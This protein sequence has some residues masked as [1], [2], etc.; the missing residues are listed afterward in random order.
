MAKGTTKKADEATESG[1][2]LIAAA[3]KMS[4]ATGSG[5]KEEE[6]QS[7]QESGEQ[8]AGQKREEQSDPQKEEQSG[9]TPEGAG[10]TNE[11]AATGSGPN[12]DENSGY[13]VY[14]QDNPATAKAMHE[15][16]VKKYGEGYVVATKGEFQSVWTKV[17]W[18]NIHGASGWKKASPIPEEALAYYRRTNAGK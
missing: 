10:K 12:T 3:N 1:A 8:Q 2:D 4:A 13:P 6:K 16:R 18:E 11:S 7:K 14:P 9:G 17:A 15:R 5:P